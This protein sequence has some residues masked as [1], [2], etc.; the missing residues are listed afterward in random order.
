MFDS[1]RFENNYVPSNVPAHVLQ[2]ATFIV[3]RILTTDEGL[4][5]CCNFGDRF[6]VVT[7]VLGKMTDK[8][9]EEPSARLLKL[10]IKCFLILSKGP[11]YAMTN[12][13]I[14]NS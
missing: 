4:N 7:H 9:L 14:L 3:E 2:V 5:Y 13:I 11:R 6:Y 8:L 1:Q 10:I 12:E